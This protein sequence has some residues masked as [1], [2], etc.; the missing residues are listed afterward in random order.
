MKKS[1][2]I[3]TVIMVVILT[4][5]ATLS[6][7]ADSKVGNTY[8]IDNV[9]VVFDV[10]SQ[11]STE[12]QE[13]IA[14]LLVNPEY[15]VAKANLICNIFGYKNTSE[16]VITITHKASATDPRCLQENFTVV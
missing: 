10:E 13:M 3:L 4:I 8:H 14:I 16:T 9:T 11:F 5:S 6:A 1:K 7:S 2:A 12:Q 15:G